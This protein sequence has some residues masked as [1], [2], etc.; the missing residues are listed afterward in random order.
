MSLASISSGGW[1]AARIHRHTRPD[2][3][4]ELDEDIAVSAAKGV[5]DQVP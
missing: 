3:Q 1:R 2:G 4:V 5:E